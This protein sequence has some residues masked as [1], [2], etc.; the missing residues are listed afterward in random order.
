LSLHRIT[1]TT[2]TYFTYKSNNFPTTISGFLIPFLAPG[3]D[4]LQ[5]ANKN[6]SEAVTD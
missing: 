6:A 5:T 3:S 2:K 1:K 4:M